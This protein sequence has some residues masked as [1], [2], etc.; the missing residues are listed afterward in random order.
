MT[1]VL[2]AILKGKQTANWVSSTLRK[3]INTLGKTIH[4]KYY[5]I[6]KLLNNLLSVY[7]LQ[8]EQ[9]LWTLEV[10]SLCSVLF[11][12][13]ILLEDSRNSTLHGSS[14]FLINIKIKIHGSELGSHGSG[15][16]YILTSNSQSLQLWLLYRWRYW[17]ISLSTEDP[18][19][20]TLTMTLLDQDRTVRRGVGKCDLTCVQRNL[21]LTW[22]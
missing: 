12:A 18:H 3:S 10:C 17:G 4:P 21:F 9:M 14:A 6:S 5:T 8:S 11:S 22:C 7:T 2:R 1:R 13:E 16:L 19:T 15:A 20:P